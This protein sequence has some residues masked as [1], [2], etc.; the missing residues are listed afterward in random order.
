MA[1]EP[2]VAA[3]ADQPRQ[4]ALPTGS[5]E[6]S[7]EDEKTLLSEIADGAVPKPEL[8]GLNEWIRWRKSHGRRPRMPL[9]ASRPAHAR[10]REHAAA[11]RDGG[12][13]RTGLACWRLKRLESLR[14]RKTRRSG[15]RA[16]HRRSAVWSR[17]SRLRKPQRRIQR[18]SA[19]SARIPEAANARGLPAPEAFAAPGTPGAGRGS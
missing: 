2:L 13:V 17:P 8:L 6:V 11:W 7:G 1:G 4:W 16:G 5:R 15:I 3:G 12:I 10:R 18:Q 14:S 9:G 19:A